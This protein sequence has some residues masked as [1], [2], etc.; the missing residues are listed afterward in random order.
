MWKLEKSHKG[1]SLVFALSGRLEQAQL[2]ELQRILAVQSEKQNVV[3][4]L[5][6]LKLVDQAVVSFLADCESS[7]IHL[8]NCPAYIR[9][10][11]RRQ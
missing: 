7:G 11:I 1:R 8:E 5:K 10:W 3:L 9:E 4:D 2:P 6:E